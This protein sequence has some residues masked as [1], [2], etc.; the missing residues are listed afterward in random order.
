MEGVASIVIEMQ[1]AVRDAG[2]DFLAH[3]RRCEGIILAT[4]DEH[5]ALDVLQVI[6]RVVR[7]GGIALRFGGV[8]GLRRRIECCVLEALLH[9]VP[10]VIVVEPGLGKD[11]HLDPLH[12]VLGAHVRLGFL[13]VLPSVEAEAILA[14]PRAHEDR[15]LHLVRMTQGELLSDDGTE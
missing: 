8:Q 7:Y 6:E 3:P 13:E 10:A 4:D 15:R 12:E 11:E 5:G 1:V 2:G 9:V 14:C